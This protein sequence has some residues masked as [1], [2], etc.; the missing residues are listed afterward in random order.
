MSIPDHQFS[1]GFCTVCG[2]VDVAYGTLTEDGFYE[3]STEKQLSWFATRVNN[4]ETELNAR[5]TADIDNYTGPMIGN[6][7]IIYAGTFDGNGH[8][9]TYITEPTEPVWSLFRK[10]SGTVKNL[11]VAGTITTSQKQCAGI[12]GFIYGATI[13]NCVCTVDIISSFS[14]DSGMGGLVATNSAAG[15][16]IKNCVFAGTIQG[17]KATSCGG[18]IGWTPQTASLINCLVI[19]EI[20]TSTSGGNTFARNPSKVTRTNCY[21]LKPYATVPNDVTQVT[22]EQLKSGEVC[23]LLN[24]GAEG[25]AFYQD[26]TTD[27]YPVFD[28]TRGIVY[29][30]GTMKCD[31]EADAISYSNTNTGASYGDH[32]FGEDGV[33][34]VCG[35]GLV[36]GIYQIS[37]AV[38][39]QWF[40][41]FVNK[42]NYKIDAVLTA[43]IDMTPVK[44][45]IPIAV[46]NENAT[47]YQGTFDGQGHTISNLA[48]H[49]DAS[50]TG[51]VGLFSHVYYGVV[52]NLIV[53]TVTITTDSE[54]PIATGAVMGRNGA[55]KMIN[56]AAIDVTFNLAAEGTDSKTSHGGLSGAAANSANTLVENCYTDYPLM[57]YVGAKAV[58]KN[59]YVGDE[60][61]AMAPTGELCYKLNQ[62]DIQNPTW[63]QSV[64][65]DAYPV[66][67]AAH[68]IVNKIGATGYATQFIAESNVLIPDGV[69]A[70]VGVINTPWIT[71][72]PL[73]NIIPAGTA[74]V[75]E[76]AEGYY[77]FIPVTVEG[78]AVNNDLKGTAAPLAADGKQYVLAEKDGVV[79]FYKADGT[80]P[81]GKAYI[82]YAG[83]AGVKGFFFG[84]ADGIEN[85]QMV[86][87]EWSNGKWY[88]LSGRRVEKP[89]KG[90]YIIN[91]KKVLR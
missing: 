4:G 15:S 52:K 65:Y 61:T 59:Y 86:N 38:H 48:I 77:S 1:D 3:L 75:L 73:T 55:S 49:R 87:D 18:I 34:S 26:L 57:G 50:N 7:E 78:A 62:G 23:Y 41:D 6:T 76:G 8:K 44:N 80:I 31:G 24:S 90:I 70:N 14:G 51:Y 11:Y 32:T 66:M 22:E 47:A 39:M 19:G 29:K 46:T 12:A 40:S 2:G 45:F 10:L 35:M 28:K 56:V 69:T 17:A 16:V 71:L 13:E 60:V 36:D 68:G 27:A 43:D 42:G 85:L 21:Y 67:D 82:E 64:G 89:T 72:T 53:K 81:A 30:V 58:C 9:I 37:K 33:C 91:G 5:L 20:S 74:V 84:D 63:R 83:A 54:T 25:M 79:G 88:D